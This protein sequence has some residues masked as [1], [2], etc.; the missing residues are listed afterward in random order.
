MYLHGHAFGPTP[1]AWAQMSVD[2]RN[3]RLI[4]WLDFAGG[5]I[6]RG[7]TFLLLCGVAAVPAYP[8]V[9]ADVLK[10][11]NAPDWVVPRPIPD[12][13]P[14]NAPTAILL[15]DQQT[16]F[17]EGK[18]VT[19]SEM[20]LKIQNPQGLA[21]GNVTLGWQPATDTVTVNKLQILR[22]N[23]VIDVLKSG[24]TFTVMRRETN[25][26]AATLDGTLTANIQP[27]GL[28]EGDTI[29]LATTNEHYDPVLK[30]HVEA[31]FGLWNGLPIEAGHAR[32]IWSDKR[33]INVR[34]SSS[35]PQFRRATAD[36]KT[37]VE[38]AGEKIDPLILPKNAPNR[39]Q[40]GRLAEASDFASWS[41]VADLMLPLFQQAATIAPS[42]ALDQEVARIRAAT[43]DPKLRAQ[44]ALSLVQD[45]IRYVAMLIG[46][47]SYVPTAAEAT[48]SRR[49]GDCKAKTALLLA[50]LQSLGIEA[51][52]VLVNSKSG[53]PVADRLPM[54]SWFDHV[55]VRARINGQDYWLDGTRTGDTSLDA[56]PVP[57]FGWSLP[58]HKNAVLVRVSPPPREVADSEQSIRI[59]ASS[60]AYAPANVTIV[61]LI[62]GDGAVALN[63]LYSQLTSDQQKEAVTKN[64][65][66]LMDSITVTSTSVKFDKAARE[67]RISAEGTAKLEWKDS[68]FYVP[69]SSLGYDPDFDRPPGQ[70]HDVPLAVGYPNFDRKRVTI[71]LP[72]ALA[73]SQK[74]PSDVQV[75]LAGTEYRRSAALKG[76]V[77]TIDTSDRSVVPEVPYKDALASAAALK[78][79]S[80]DNVYLSINTRYQWSDKDLAAK[81][82][83]T[84]DSQ[85]EF[86]ERGLK[87]MSKGKLDEAIADFTEGN[88]ADPKSIWPLAN[89]ALAYIHKNDEQSAEKDLKA[90][91]AIDPNN[92]VVLRTRAMQAEQKN[93]C[94]AAVAYLTQSLTADPQSSFAL[95]HRA[96]CERTLGKD[97][98]ALVDSERALKIDPTFMDLRVM[99][100]NLFLFRAQNDAVA[101]EAELLVQQNPNS[102]YAFVAAGKI[103]ARID[104]RADAMKAFDRALALKPEA[105]VYINRSQV[106]PY[107]DK[108]GR[109]AD[110]DTALKLEPGNPDAILQK[111]QQLVYDGQYAEALKL[112]D[113]VHV[114][115]DADYFTARRAVVLYKLGRKSEAGSLLDSIR[116]KAK[117]SNDFNRL[118][119]AKATADVMMDSALGD[120]QEAIRLDP[121]NIAAV[122]SL[123]LVLLRL[124]KLDDSIAAYDKAVAKKTGSASYMGRA[125]AYAR[126]GDSARA[127]ADRAEALKLDEDVEYRFASFG[128]KL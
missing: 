86:V 31:I 80:D 43:T 57:D 41:D 121:N 71:R 120:C 68:W 74:L 24:Q 59:D 23:Q 99:R 16:R 105:Y 42:S 8:A 76:D 63:A 18:I 101:H 61:Q 58:L 93:D 128:L 17:D 15:S 64:A 49:F 20:A 12:A 117:S 46:Q 91:A 55:L 82:S 85:R 87:L 112:Y 45:R 70:L 36:G 119:W 109:L 2:Q 1:P 113:G 127:A 47:G 75:T 26:E 95:G 73:S 38:I 29:V 125:L 124:G 106:R 79:L 51:E 7:T 123:G 126:K 13:R 56:I 78:K 88:K 11:G 30:G 25:L 111:A 27:E 52:P 83:E 67:L 34:E 97:E 77:I 54:I 48:W 107:S 104:R 21:A 102:D 110:L 32:V 84:P 115:E 6:V 98:E 122:D 69:N 89:R 62:R 90:A 118:C 94:A 100:A 92:A 81:Q 5:L 103:Y 72:A 96:L 33:K 10:I 50:V 60:G 4:G 9:A 22:G 3:S 44:Q 39:F 28:Q 114:D 108:A 116:S 19:Y 53:D 35:L 65:K 37:S 66:N 14:S 40:I